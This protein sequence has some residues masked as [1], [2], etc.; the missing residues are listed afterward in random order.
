MEI[1]TETEV[2]VSSCLEVTSNIKNTHKKYIYGLDKNAITLFLQ[3]CSLDIE[4]EGF[5]VDEEPK[6]GNMYFHKPIFVKNIIEKKEDVQVLTAYSDATIRNKCFIKTPIEINKKLCNKNV[7]I[8]GAGAVGIRIKK[9]F[10]KENIN[11]RYFVDTDIRKVGTT[12]EGVSVCSKDILDILPTDTS[13][14]MAG[15]YWREINEILKKYGSFDRYYIE[16]QYLLDVEECDNTVIVDYE[17]NIK[18]KSHAIFALDEHYANRKI[19]IYGTQAS[20][21]DKCARKYRMFGFENISIAVDS[22]IKLG[23]S[24]TFPVIEIDNIMYEEN[25]IILVQ[26]VSRIPKLDELGL[27][28]GVNYSYINSCDGCFYRKAVW[29]VNLGHTYIEHKYCN[30]TQLYIYGDNKENDYKVAVLG[31]STSEGGRSSIWTWAEYLIKDHAPKGVTVYNYATSAYS[32]GQQLIKLIRDVI[33]LRPNLIISYSG[34]NDIFQRG[35]YSSAFAF[36]YLCHIF[37]S[38]IRNGMTREVVYGSEDGIESHERWLK[39]MQYMNAIAKV[40]DMTFC[41]FLQPCLIC[42][43]NLSYHEKTIIQTLSSMY[44][45]KELEE[46]KQLRRKMKNIGDKYSFICDLSDIFDDIDVYMDLLHVYDEGNRIIAHHIWNK[47]HSYIE[48]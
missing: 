23:N 10:E 41:A 6:G 25:Y 46:C 44:D 8:Y 22:C 5:V 42:K 11:V 28:E 21:L 45:K 32:S 31:D 19:I 3:L 47:I 37:S 35:D 12:I 43:D 15:K 16:D 40:N 2:D 34:Y 24:L 38:A 33:P 39:N 14:V 7:V 18:L 48:F 36:P 20:I 1:P 17:N 27:Q 13:I 9:Y 4:I 26:D 29:D 30:Q